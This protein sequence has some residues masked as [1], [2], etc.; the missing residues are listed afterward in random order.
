MFNLLKQNNYNLFDGAYKTDS[1]GFI[2][3]ELFMLQKQRVD[4]R[5][6]ITIDKEYKDDVKRSSLYHLQFPNI[7]KRNSQLIKDNKFFCPYLVIDVDKI[8]KDESLF[9]VNYFKKQN[10][11]AYIEKSISGNGLHIYVSIKQSFTHSEFRCFYLSLA[12]ELYLT[13]TFNF[14]FIDLSL[15]VSVQPVFFSGDTL[16]ENKEFYRR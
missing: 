1:I 9:I 15:S 8:S 7:I 4:I 14:K 13:R 3:D 10:Y 6:D 5:R 12:R 11:T 2:N 16:Y